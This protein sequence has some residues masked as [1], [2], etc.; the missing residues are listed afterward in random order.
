MRW[1]FLLALFLGC[2][3]ETPAP[4]SS[5]PAAATTETAADSSP[6]KIVPPVSWEVKALE[7]APAGF[8]PA[9]WSDE[10]VLWGIARD[11]KVGRLDTKSGAVRTIDSS[12]WS[13]HAARGVV[14]WRNE[15][16]TWL[17]REG[18][19]P[20]LLAGPEPDRQSG[21]DGP[22]TILF[23]PDGRRAV[24]GWQGEWDSHFQLLRADGNRRRLD[25]GLKGYFLNSA[26]LWLDATHVLFQTVANGPVGGKPTYRESGWRG[27]LAVLD[28]NSGRYRR[29]TNVPDLTFLRVAGRYLEDVLVTETNGEGVRTQ[30]LYDPET[31][32]RREISLPPGRPF[33]SPAGALIVFLDAEGDNADAVLITRDKQRELGRVARDSEPAFTPSGRRGSMLTGRT[34]TIF[35]ATAP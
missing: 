13:V 20:R 1:F 4:R 6:E 25:T 14:G 34:V 33:A 24:L 5:A 31:W 28:V 8:R 35:E 29:V 16:G 19:E 32:K 11:G 30:W 12:A 2:S 3:R 9:G 22:P 10:E 26:V 21:F 27:D 15:G 7:S 17:M 18:K 23:S